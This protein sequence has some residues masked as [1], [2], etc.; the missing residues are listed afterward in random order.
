VRN[1]SC[2][3]IKLGFTDSSEAG[4]RKSGGHI[5]TGPDHDKGKSC[6]G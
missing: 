3:I 6:H 2:A 1:A 4:Q 5:R